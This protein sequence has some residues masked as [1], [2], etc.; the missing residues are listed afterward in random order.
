VSNRSP[1]RTRS[2]LSFLPLSLFH[3]AYS[4]S[5]LTSCGVEASVRL[6][7]LLPSRSHFALI[8]PITP[9]SP[10]R[11]LPF[12]LFQSLGVYP[13]S[14][15]PPPAM[16]CGSRCDFDSIQPPLYHLTSR[17]LHG[18]L[19]SFV[20]GPMHCFLVHALVLRSHYLVRSHSSLS[21]SSSIA[22]H[23]QTLSSLTLPTHSSTHQRLMINTSVLARLNNALLRSK[24]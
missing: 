14:A 10:Y 9:A 17:N 16:P 4:P 22:S 11:A 12:R 18:L 1:L 13:P 3:V 23:A 21:S 6:V 15:A 2:A 5:L 7:S 8:A 19:R 24:S 20:P